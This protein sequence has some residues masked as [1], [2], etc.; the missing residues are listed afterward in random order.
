MPAA[1]SPMGV[2]ECPHKK[3]KKERKSLK[4]LDLTVIT[5]PASQ[6]ANFDI[7][8]RKSSKISCKRFHGKTCFFL[9]A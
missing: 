6:K 5:Q 1:F 9:L 8:A 3:E 7:C 4:C 2:P